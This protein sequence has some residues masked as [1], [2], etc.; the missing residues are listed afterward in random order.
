[1]KVKPDYIDNYYDFKGIWDVPS[2]CGLKIVSKEDKSIVIATELYTQNPGTSVTNCGG[3]LAQQVC[4]EFDILPGKM[5]FVEHIPDQ[6]S[7]LE[8]Y[9]EAFFIVHFE[10]NGESFI[11]PKW[12]KINKDQ[13]ELLIV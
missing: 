5:I 11:N 9:N 12:E 2:R 13:L 3:L 7:R 1:M 10:W 6:G 8:F 4:N